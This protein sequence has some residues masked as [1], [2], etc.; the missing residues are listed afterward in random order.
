M[1]KY[2]AIEFE[3]RGVL[4]ITGYR[5]NFE[6]KTLVLESKF[7]LRKPT[8]LDFFLAYITLAIPAAM[9]ARVTRYITGRKGTP[10][11]RFLMGHYY[12]M[13]VKLLAKDS[14]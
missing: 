9:L 7:D 2:E 14:E 13:S 3:K 12:D 11:E 8:K 10:L 1:N 6:D 5:I 4:H